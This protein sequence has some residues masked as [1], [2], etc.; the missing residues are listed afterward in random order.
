MKI[1]KTSFFINKAKL[2]HGDKYDYSLVEYKNNYTKVN[3]LCSKHGEFEQTPYHHT[4]RNHGC[5]KC[6]KTKRLTNDDFISE[7]I[8]IHGNKYD[9]SKVNYKN[10]KS[11]I[12]IICPKHGEFKQIPES[13]IT[14]KTGCPK[15]SKKYHYSTDEFIRIVSSLHND[16][17]DYSVVNYKNNY[18]KIKIICPEHGE[19]EQTP[20]NH[21]QGKGC[22]LCNESKGENI[23]KLWL[24]KNN[25]KYIRQHRFI[26]C[27][28]KRKLP[29]DFY[30]PEHNICIEFNGK[31]HY[32]PIK[33]WGGEDGLKSQQKRDNIK[34]NYC[35]N[36]S[37]K[38]LTIKY[39]ENIVSK[40]S[41][42]V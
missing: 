19:F 25:I 29:F 16:K 14:Q 34:I 41:I 1:N 40:L 21:L 10:M 5:P 3:I 28:Y 7:A 26:D 18:T 9:Y 36:K 32:N 31:Q 4:N 2:I 17:Y 24:E 11:I 30:L 42:I 15:C 20:S 12:Y 13:H 6:S 35:K 33:Y 23:I 39:N 38:L 37:I 22:E 8:K 27:V